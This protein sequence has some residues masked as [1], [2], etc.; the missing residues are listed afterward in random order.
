MSHGKAKG[1]HVQVHEARVLDLKVLSERKLRLREFWEISHAE[2][3]SGAP[4]L[5]LEEI[6]VEVAR[7]RGDGQEAECA[8]IRNDFLILH[9]PKGV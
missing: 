8:E 3:A 4:Q 9:G 7:L 6:N 5:T 2:A 1:D